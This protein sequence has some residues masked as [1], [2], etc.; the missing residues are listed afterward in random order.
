MHG[1]SNSTPN[2]VVL[3]QVIRGAPVLLYRNAIARAQLL[4]FA[5]SSAVPSLSMTVVITE[6]GTR[7]KAISPD[8]VAALIGAALLAILLFPTIAGVLLQRTATP[9]SSPGTP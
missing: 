2:V 8:V 5:L 7:A 3:L 1:I 9:V 4:P 6:I